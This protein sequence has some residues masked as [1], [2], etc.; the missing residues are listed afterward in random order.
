MDIKYPYALV[1][2]KVKELMSW[3]WVVCVVKVFRE[4]NRAVDCL[5]NLGHSLQL[6]VCLYFEPPS[7]LYSTLDDDLV[8][9]AMPRLVV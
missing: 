4:A 5:A 9:A 3:N 2:R 1:I 8:G 6:G 7:C